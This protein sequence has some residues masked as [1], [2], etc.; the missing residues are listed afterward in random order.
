MRSSEHQPIILNLMRSEGGR[1]T[2]TRQFHSDT[3]LEAIDELVSAK[4]I[5]C[6]TASKFAS[7][8]EYELCYSNAE[9]NLLEELN[10]N[11]SISVTPG[12]QPQQWRAASDLVLRGRIVLIAR[13]GATLEYTT[14]QRALEYHYPL[15]R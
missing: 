6:L 15:A 9:M 1:L 12:F 13:Y 4:V 10:W 8:R 5:R 3:Y 11:H 7:R 2:V 14:T